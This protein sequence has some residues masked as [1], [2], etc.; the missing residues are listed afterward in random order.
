M[1][2]FNSIKYILTII[3]VA[4]AF[5]C[6]SC[7]MIYE[8]MEAC[9]SG[10]RLRFI[11]DRNMEFANAFPSQVDCL[12]VLVYDS[13]G[14]YFGTRTANRPDTSD[15]NWRM[16]LD[17]PAGNYTLLAY[18]GVECEKASFSFSDDPETIGLQD[19]EVKLNPELLTAP[20]G[21]P[22]H[23]LF[24]G[25][26]DI[27][28]PQT[29][30]EYTEETLY[31]TKDTN[32]IRIVLAAESGSPVD[33]SDFVFSITDDNTLLGWDNDIISTGTTYY[34]PWVTG[35]I[36]PGANNSGDDY[37]MAFAEFSVSRLV[38]NSRARLTITRISDGMQ[39]AGIDLVNILLMLKSERFDYMEAQ[40]FLDRMSVWNLTFFLSGDGI[41]NKTSIVVNDWVVRFNYFG[42]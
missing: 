1:K 8:D 10:V 11:Y 16:T 14:N 23:H 12:K 41:W 25:R 20:L 36:T 42:S 3:S 9:P 37:Q 7:N 31:M 34:N 35:N 21:K 32:D 2:L 30:A 4:A 18:G 13:E 19:V 27:T 24:Y 15:E 39:V 5:F 33:E 26:L 17:L 22:L 38:E 40:E 29:G 28:I 6:S